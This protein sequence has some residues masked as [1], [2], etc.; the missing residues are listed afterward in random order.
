MKKDQIKGSLIIAAAAFLWG[1][2]FV[3]QKEGGVIGTFSF[4]T[5][6]FWIG[7]AVL[8]I[9]TLMVSF[10]RKKEGSDTGSALFTKEAVKGGII[11]GIFYFAACAFQQLGLETIPA[12][13]SGFL[14]APYTVIV[15]F[16]SLFL[17]KKVRPLTFL[18]AFLC[19]LGLFFLCSTGSSQFS[20]FGFGD[21]MTLVS[22]FIWALQIMAVDRYS[23]TAHPVVLSLLQTGTA[24]I[25][26]TIAMLLRENPSAAGFVSVLPSLLFVGICSS[27]IAF[28]L[29]FIGQRYTTPT[30]A[31]ILM[32][33][34]SVFSVL[35]GWLILHE[36]MQ[37]SQLF[38]CSFI[39]LAAVLSQLPERKPKKEASVS[40]QTQE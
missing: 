3:F 30:Q 1:V 5:G 40:A 9:L 27:G 31:A 6:R 4:M 28:T 7:T 13:K 29:Q 36:T 35:A 39:F 10:H 23:R 32:N 2:A 17:G 19:L 25:F 20:G 33:F 11:C 38:G 18:S 12:G 21:A 24:A 14:T 37:L 16:L 26:S 34:E 22:A 15:P 8:L